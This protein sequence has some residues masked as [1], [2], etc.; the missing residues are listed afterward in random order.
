MNKKIAAAW[1]IC[2]G[3]LLILP[4]IIWAMA[5]QHF[6]TSATENITV[7]QAPKLTKENYREFPGEFE[8]Y[9]NNHVPFRSQLITLSSLADVNLF[10]EK[11]IN[12][13]VVIGKNNW[14]FLSAQQNMEDYKGT[15]LFTR[16][17]LET[18]VNNLL[19]SKDYLDKRGIEFV[20]FIAPNKDHPRKRS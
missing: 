14:L 15:N 13:K 4:Q 17:Q 19:T 1:L 20:L 2:F 12:D 11:N 5:G 18:V 7:T 8:N 9:F 16:E 6:T 10:R 3:L